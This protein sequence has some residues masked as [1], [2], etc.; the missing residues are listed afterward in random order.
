MRSRVLS[1]TAL[2]LLACSP[3]KKAQEPMHTTGPGGPSGMIP[4][5]S[6]TDI[7]GFLDVVDSDGN[8]AGWALAKSSSASSI[9]VAFY[10]QGDA[11]SGHLLGKVRADRPRG[12]VNSTVHV[13]GDH[14]F[15][16]ALP[17]SMKDGK[18]R[19]VHAYGIGPAGAPVEL[20]QSPMTVVLESKVAIG[21]LD[22]VDQ[23]GNALGWSLVPSIAPDPSDVHFYVDGTSSTG[24]SIGSVTANLPRPGLSQSTGWPGDDHGFSYRLPDGVRDGAAHALY[25]YGVGP[26]GEALLQPSPLMFTLQP[27]YP[28]R[29]GSVRLDGRSLVDDTGHFNALGATLFSASRWYKTDRARLER[30]LD[31][32]A[33]NGYEYIRVL[34]QVGWSGREIDPRW[35]DYDAVIAGLTDLAFDKYGIRVHWTIFGG[36]D[37]TPAPADRLAL[38]DRFIAMS[39]GREQKIMFFETANEYWQNGFGGAA[40]QELL[41]LTRHLNGATTILVAASS[42]TDSNDELTLDQAG[43]ADLITVHPDRNVGVAP[44]GP[45]RAVRQPWGEPNGNGVAA[46][47]EPIGPGSS[48]ASER[49]PMRLVMHA[50]TAY[51]SQLPFYTFHSRAGVG[52]DYANCD[53]LGTC[54]LNGDKDIADMPGANSFMAMK[55]YMPAGIEAWSKQNHYWAGHPFNVYGDGMLN[56]M[57]TDGAQNGVMRAY[58]AVSPAGEFV[59]ALLRIVGTLTLQAKAEMKFCAIHPVTGDLIGRYTLSAGQ[60]VNLS[61]L[62]GMV[63]RGKNGGADDGCQDY[64]ISPNDVWAAS[65]VSAAPGHGAVTVP[66]E[67]WANI[68]VTNTGNTTWTQGAVAFACDATSNNFTFDLGVTELHT[69]DFSAWLDWPV[70]PGATVGMRPLITPRSATPTGQLVNVSYVCQLAHGATRFGPMTPPIALQLIQN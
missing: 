7:I 45:W 36:I 60:M 26:K 59:V 24:V 49:D 65:I 39:Q 10:T 13:P 25:A 62:E 33:R 69:T 41:D 46:D 48:V 51:I 61:G 20:S 50:V 38:V 8:A 44:D 31:F 5:A 34:G 6:S 9:E 63:L 52:A 67:T 37:F 14:G 53:A 55:R 32:L 57:T 12:D 35:P 22:T 23:D 54:D 3:A 17:E 1:F 42:A 4:S 58:A 43:V 47:D 40:E 66:A 15:S 16:F 30:N 28:R 64:S 27:V 19:D 70:S 56:F 29:A 18:P 11:A 2:A 21:Y 68:V